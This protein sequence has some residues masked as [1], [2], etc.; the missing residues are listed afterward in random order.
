MIITTTALLQP[1]PLQLSSGTARL[2]S[3]APLC[4]DALALLDPS[5]LVPLPLSRMITELPLGE[6]LAL[7]ETL[8]QDLSLPQLHLTRLY[9]VDLDGDGTPEQLFVANTHPD[10]LQV[11]G[12]VHTHSYTGLI[13]TSAAGASQVLTYSGQRRQHPAGEHPNEHSDLI[14]LTDINGDGSLEVVTVTRSPTR[15]L[16]S[17][18]SIS[19]G[20]LHHIGDASCPPQESSAAAISPAQP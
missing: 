3:G 15:E 1:G 8:R 18:V 10:Q 11:T 13:R 9:Q 16:R 12:P 6:D 7:L 19:Q 20:M 4:P 14:G 5:A 2:Q 17:V